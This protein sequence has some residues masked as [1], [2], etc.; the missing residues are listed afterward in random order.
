MITMM[1][2]RRIALSCVECN[3]TALPPVPVDNAASAENKN[4]IYER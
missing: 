3:N 2:T 4:E 1:K